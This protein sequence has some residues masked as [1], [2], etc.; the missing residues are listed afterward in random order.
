MYSHLRE[1]KKHQF[2]GQKRGGNRKYFI[3]DF[4][5]SLLPQHG[6][7]LSSHSAN[8]TWHCLDCCA[9]LD[10]PSGMAKLM[11]V[12]QWLVLA[13]SRLKGVRRD[14]GQ[15]DLDSNSY[16]FKNLT[17]PCSRSL[18]RPLP[19]SHQDRGSHGAILG[20]VVPVYPLWLQGQQGA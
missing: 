14:T 20:E 4:L 15:G 12:G 6:Q 2:S 1:E 13:E 10:V 9:H 11:Q 16:A 8:A 5:H 3:T 19:V 17:S 7:S 18:H